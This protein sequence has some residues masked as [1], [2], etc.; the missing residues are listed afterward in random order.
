MTDTR[1]HAT[2]DDVRDEIVPARL[3]SLLRD[4]LPGGKRSGG[5]YM[6][7]SPFRDDRNPSLWVAL[8]TGAWCDEGASDRSDLFGL[9]IYVKGVRDR[10]AAKIWLSDWLGWGHGIDRAKLETKRK[11]ATYTRAQDERMARQKAQKNANR[12]K[13]VFFNARPFMGTPVETYLRGRGIELDSFKRL[14]GAIRFLHDQQHTDMDG[15][16]SGWPCMVAAMTDDKGEV[17]AIHRT[18]LAADGRGKAPVAPVKKIWPSFTGCVIRIWKGGPVLTPEQAAKKHV[19]GHCIVCEGI[20]DGLS[21][22]LATPELRVWAAGTLGNMA[23]VPDHPCVSGWIL[24]RDNDDG[25]P[26]AIAAF[27]KAVKHFRQTGKPV[28]VIASPAGKDF[29]DLLKGDLS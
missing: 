8:N 21:L 20:E 26:Q 22:A 13:A 16:I 4:I 1:E 2:F 11:A 29:N 14:P 28:A 27:D 17:R 15:V 10:L 3:E 25:K 24:A 23:A 7:S 18:W 19:S 6:A 12:A 9:I 5:Y